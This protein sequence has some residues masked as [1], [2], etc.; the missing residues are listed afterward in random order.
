MNEKGLME[1][2]QKINR[3]RTQMDEDKGRRKYLLQEL[4]NKHD[5]KTIGEAKK[6][7]SKIVKEIEELDK[8]IE[9]GIEQIE[10]DYN[11]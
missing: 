9:Q 4:E 1:L 2:K 6:L 5:C 7:Q 8:Q 11:A 10:E 3:V